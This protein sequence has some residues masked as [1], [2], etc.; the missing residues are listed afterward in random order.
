MAWPVLNE[1]LI[2]FTDGGSR[3]NLG[4]SVAAWIIKTHLGDDFINANLFLLHA[5]NNIIEYVVVI[6][7]LTNSLAF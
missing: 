7:S 2:I 6:G 3:E 1:H 4:P 5:T